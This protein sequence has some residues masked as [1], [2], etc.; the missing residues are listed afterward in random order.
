MA[1]FAER[2][3]FIGVAEKEQMRRQDVWIVQYHAK[4]GRQQL[5]AVK[6]CRLGMRTLD[7]HILII[8]GH[9][10]WVPFSALHVCEGGIT[11][12]FPLCRF[13]HVK[14]DRIASCLKDLIVFVENSAANF[15]CAPG[16]A[17]QSQF[18]PNYSR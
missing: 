4:E 5:Q 14:G 16:K 15:I 1:L 18:L 7:K 9:L 3:A 10:V 8:R 2:N 6:E 11:F 12:V 17:T 13:C